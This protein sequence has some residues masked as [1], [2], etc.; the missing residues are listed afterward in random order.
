VSL[1]ER[2]FAPS[3]QRR[4]SHHHHAIE[5]AHHTDAAFLFR[6]LDDLHR[7]HRFTDIMQGAAR[8]ADALAKDWAATPQDHFSAFASRQT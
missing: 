8:G 2:T 1:S 3:S 7:E 5:H 4:A 6:T